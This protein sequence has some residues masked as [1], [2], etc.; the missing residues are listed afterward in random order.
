LKLD[1]KARLLVV[2]RHGL[3]QND[4]PPVIDGEG[5]ACLLAR[6]DLLLSIAQ[7][8]LE[9]VHLRRGLRR[10]V[11]LR[12][13]D[14]DPEADDDSENDDPGEDELLRPLHGVLPV[15]DTTAVDASPLEDSDWLSVE[16]GA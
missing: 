10:I 7:R 11:A 6:R 8:R 16:A 12:A 15:P 14:Q 13:E 5:P 9:L 2:G 1:Q 3:A 4:Q